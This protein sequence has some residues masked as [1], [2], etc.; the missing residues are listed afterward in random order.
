MGVVGGEAGKRTS[1]KVILE[2]HKLR[3]KPEDKIN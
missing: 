1:R 2:G 3:G